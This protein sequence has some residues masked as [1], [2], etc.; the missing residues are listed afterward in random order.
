M[1]E[2]VW[3]VLWTLLWAVYFLL[4][5]FDLGIGSLMPFLASDEEQKKV[6]YSASGPFWDGNEVWLIAAGGVTFAAFPKVYAVM[7]SALYAPLLILLFALILRAASYEFREHIE[8]ASWRAVWDWTH[9]IVNILACVVLGVFFAN[10][11]RGIPFDANGVYF[12]NLLK[13]F[14]IYG[15]AGGIFFLLI[16]MMHGAIWLS[17]KSTGQLKDK[18]VAAAGV[19]WVGVACMLLIFLVL[20]AF[21]TNIYSNY[22]RMPWLIILPVL[23][24][25]GLLYIPRA[26]NHGKSFLA[27][28]SSGLFIV[29]VTFF[30]VMGIYPNMLISSMDPA[31]TITAFNGSST[32]L[33]LEIMLVVCL[34][35]VPIVL[36]YQFWMYR[37]FSKPVP[38][39]E[40][41]EHLY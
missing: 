31:A 25:I 23:A 32:T 22:I 4:D 27:W 3:F 39:S 41:D 29:S 33:T 15:I 10:L 37:L 19:L 35:M 36:L 20:T 6:M 8:H 40:L 9:F 5:G 17:I 2:T 34:V 24:V 13:L 18:A 7:F 11:F 38:P 12:G 14:N 30:G 26:L 1:L 21:Y 28:A 16:F